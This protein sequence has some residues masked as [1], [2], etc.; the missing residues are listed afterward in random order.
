[1]DVWSTS[2]AYWLNWRVF[3]C[4]I[5]LL[6]TISMASYVVKKY[7]GPKGPRS[8]R[9]QEE[10]E[11]DIGIGSYL[12]AYGCYHE[13]GDDELGHTHPY[14]VVGIWGYMFQIIYQRFPLFRIAYFGIWT[15]IYV[16]SHWL[17]HVCIPMWWPSAFLNLSAPLAPLWYFLIILFHVPSYGVFYLI[18]KAKNWRVFLCSLCLLTTITMTSY[19]IKKYEGP[20][21]QGTRNEQEE[22]EDDDIGVLFEHELWKTCWRQIHPALLMVYRIFDLLLVLF[23][24]IVDAILYGGSVLGTLQLS[25]LGGSSTRLGGSSN[26]MG[27]LLGSHHQV[28]KNKSVSYTLVKSKGKADNIVVEKGRMMVSEAILV[29]SRCRGKP[30]WL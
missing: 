22:E 4:F 16:F 9:E 8:T 20:K 18:V 27:D 6:T 19:V 17:I 24:S 25:M 30:Y 3:L 29:P 14:Q 12:S 23:I 21:E 13:G 11:D 26:G 2:V 10:V 15:C 7:E 28:A 5:S 1:M